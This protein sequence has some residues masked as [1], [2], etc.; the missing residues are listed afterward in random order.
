VSAARTPRT[1]DAVAWAGYSWVIRIVTLGPRPIIWCAYG[2]D[3]D[4][5]G[6]A[7]REIPAK[8]WAGARYDDARRCWI[9]APAETA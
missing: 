3:W 1:G 2:G 7:H 8:L 4:A 5:R 6:V 9:I